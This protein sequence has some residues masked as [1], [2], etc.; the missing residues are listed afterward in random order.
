MQEHCGV[1][2][3][4]TRQSYDQFARPVRRWERAARGSSWG[5]DAAA[6]LYWT[7]HQPGSLSGNQTAYIVREWRAPRCYGNFVRRHYDGLGQLILDQQPDEAWEA[8]MDGCG[9]GNLGQEI[10]HYY[11]Y[12]ALGNQTRAAAPKLVN[13][14][15]YATRTA[16]WGPGGTPGYAFNSYDA[17]NRPTQSLAPNGETTIFAYSGR[18]SNVYVRDRTKAT[19]VAEAYKSLRWQQTDGLGFVNDVRALRYTG[20]AW[21]TISQVLLSHDVLGNLTQ[22]THPASTG[23]T[24]LSYDMGGRKTS[25]SDPD[26]GYWGYAYDRQGKLIGQSDA[27]GNVTNLSYDKLERLTG[28]SYTKGSNT[29]CNT[30]NVAYSVSFSYDQG[31]SSSNRSRG[32]LTQVK[33]SDNS[34]QKDLDYNNLGQLLSETVYIGGG[35]TS[36][37]TSIY[38]Y[39]AFQRPTSLSY[40]DNEVVA[41]YTNPM[42]LPSR[43]Y[44]N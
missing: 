5:T 23:V 19:N 2:D 9:S 41:T 29:N 7:Y 28:K 21:S 4:C 13:R 8:A 37:Y 25:L 26:L 38:G 3:S 18:A 27:C 44:S 15:G 16:D 14:S 36:G 30:A 33:Y 6:N 43:L 10:E 39:D 42:A 34:Y 35:A 32:Q 17:L 20:S 40:P 31:H 24:T 12:D 22:V 1:N 11:A